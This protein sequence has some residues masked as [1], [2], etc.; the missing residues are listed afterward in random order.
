MQY[1]LWNEWAVS[2]KFE[3]TFQ[4]A[5]L[6]IVSLLPGGDGSQLQMDGEAVLGNVFGVELN[7]N[8]MIRTSGMV[9]APHHFQSHSLPC[10]RVRHHT[11]LSAD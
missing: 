7:Q 6:V 1:C 8:W 11:G 2:G 3:L 10:S 9:Y 5:I 4:L